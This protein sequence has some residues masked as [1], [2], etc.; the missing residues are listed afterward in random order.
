M[1]FSP[2]SA[3]ELA[4]LLALH[5]HRHPEKRTI[6]VLGDGGR[7]VR[8]PF[9]LGNPTGATLLDGD[10]RMP[11][12]RRP[13]TAWSDTVRVT[14]NL[15]KDGPGAA[16][17]L[18]EDC[19]LWPGRVQLAQWAERWPAL[20]GTLVDPVQRK[21]GGSKVLETPDPDDDAP[22]APIAEALKATPRAVWRFLA[23]RPDERFA[24]AIESPDATTWRFFQ[25]ETNKAEANV[26]PV[27]LDVVKNATRA[28]C[29]ADGAPAGFELTVARWPGLAVALFT[30]VSALGG[31]AAAVEE[32]GW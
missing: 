13:T 1:D 28:F 31:A 6:T 18:V 22:P 30:V 4:R 25:E 8:L 17:A 3:E 26:W 11:D 7:P 16:Q 20:Y 27:V 10:G 29:R 2:P 24:V 19:V 5:A 12:G 23:P 21:L 14:L 32:G 15:A 9:V